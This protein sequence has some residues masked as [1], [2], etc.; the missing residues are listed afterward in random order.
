MGQFADQAVLLVGQ[1]HSLDQHFRGM[2]QC[3]VGAGPDQRETVSR[4]TAAGEIDVVHHAQSG[5]ERGYLVG[6][7]QA[8]AN[9]LVRREDRHIL[10][11]EADQTRRREKIP[12]DAVEQR[13][14]ACAVRAENGS[15]F[16]RFH[17]KRDV[18]DSGQCAEHLADAAQFERI[19]GGGI[20]C[21]RQVHP[22]RRDG[23]VHAPSPVVAALR[24]VTCARQRSHR[25]ST[26]S[27]E[28]STIAR[29]PIP[30]MSLK[31]STEN[32]KKPRISAE[33]TCSST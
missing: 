31:R 23:R 19:A 12:G 28:N 5:E 29:K 4:N 14:L 2:H 15:P 3:I 33:N 32:P 13:G 20:A 10:A 1:M 6:A 26:P 24:A 17:R 25:P 16:A 22:G 8:P 21:P 30:M 18:R 9:A 11:E 7:A 27:G